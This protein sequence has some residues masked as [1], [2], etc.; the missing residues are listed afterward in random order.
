MAWGLWEH[1]MRG[2]RAASRDSGAVL[3]WGPGAPRP[4]TLNVALRGDTAR[5]EYFGD[6]MVMRLD[7]RGRLLQVDGTGTTNKVLATRVADVDVA[8]LARRLRPARRWARRRRP[9]AP[10]P[11]WVRRRSPWCTADRACAG[12]RCGAARWSRTAR[13]GARA[14]TP[15][16]RSAPPPTC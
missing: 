8:A 11:R 10:R 3:V 6:P 5:V 7:A 1:A 16:P 2:M 12:A 4:Q 15:R 14:R 9:T 13:S